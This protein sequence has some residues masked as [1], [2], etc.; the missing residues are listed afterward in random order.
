MVVLISELSAILVT[1]LLHR[2]DFL[3]NIGMISLYY[4][5]TALLST[6][7]LCLFRDKLNSLVN[8]QTIIGAAVCCFIPFLIT[9]LISQ[10]ISYGFSFLAL[11]WSRLISFSIV[12]LIMI[13]LVLRLFS[14]FSVLEQRN[15]AEMEM[16]LQALQSRIRPHFLF[17]SLNT[18]A[19]LTATEPK[20]AEQAIS[21][22][23][24]LFRA[25]LESEKRFHNLQNELNLCE[26]YIQLERWR[27]DNRLSVNWSVSVADANQHYVPKLILQPLIENAI[28]HGVQDDGQI[29]VNIDVRETKY[30]LSIVVENSVG[31]KQ[32]LNEGHGIAVENIRERLFV[33]YDDKQIFRVR[34]ADDSYSVLMRFPKQSLNDVNSAI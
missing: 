13:L 29:K 15:R 3:S 17:N 32:Q 20:Q 4:Q 6:A 16:R 12:A 34:E 21:S 24:L 30:E 9:E 33:L 31:A 22:L 18:I 23:S 5:W 7:T 28:V 25:S 1:L 11:D 8:I 10:Y 14:I 27:L 2:Q 19:E 26:R